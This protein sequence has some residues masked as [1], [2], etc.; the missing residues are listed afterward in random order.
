[1][2]NVAG[3]IADPQ[4][5]LPPDSIS[6]Q[7]QN[8]LLAVPLTRTHPMQLRSNP[9]P[10]TRYPLPSAHLIEGPIEVEPTCFTEADKHDKWRTA[11][12]T[13]FNALLKNG[14]WSL[15]PPQSHQNVI[16]SKWVFRIKRKAD[17][18]VEHYKA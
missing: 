10:S 6:A 2:N 5:S 8:H 7:A 12:E 16:G 9:R 14:T 3:V 13:E 1:M 17:G 4:P 15:V 11:M 18:M